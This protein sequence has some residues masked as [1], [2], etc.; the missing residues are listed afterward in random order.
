[1]QLPIGFRVVLDAS[2]RVDGSLVWGG[3]PWRL[4][5]LTAAGAATLAALRDGEP[6]SD[7]RSGMLARRLV[8]AGLAHPVPPAAAAAADVDVVVPVRDRVAQLDTCLA[9]LAGLAKTVVDDGSTDGAAVA[10]VAARHGAR[11]VRRNAAGGPAAARNL[12]LEHTGRPLVAFVDSDCVANID[13]LRRVAGHL[14]DPCVGAAAPRVRENEDPS[15]LDL[16]A[17]AALVRP[18]GRVPFV[19]TTALVV[20][21]TAIDAVGGFDESLRYG[22]DVD[23]VWRLSADGWSVRY[24]P[25]VVVQHSAPPTL[26]QALARKYRYGTSAGPLASRH[27]SAM[28]GPA[29]AGFVAPLQMGRLRAAGMPA[30]EALRITAASP[31]HTATALLKWSTPSNLGDAAYQLGVWRGCV[32]ARTLKPLLPK[33]R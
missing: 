5:R 9:A 7:L 15:P 2:T 14:A 31:I 6:V 13:A 20:R 26:R 10:A 23:L 25:S 18:G 22:E 3:M 21:R 28:G 24:D 12:G 4:L 19:P 1:M 29:L 17:I 32:A 27:G 11:V 33:V 30:A 8:D 16:G